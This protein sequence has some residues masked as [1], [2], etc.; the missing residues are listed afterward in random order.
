MLQRDET[1][2]GGW[3]PNLLTRSDPDTFEYVDQIGATRLDEI[4]RGI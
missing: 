3:G 1:G 2:N 4:F